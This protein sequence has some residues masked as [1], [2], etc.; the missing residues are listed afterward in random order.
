MHSEFIDGLELITAAPAKDTGKPPLLF[1]HGAFAGA[2]M[3]AERL[4]PWFAAQGYRASAVSLRGHGESFGRDQV[5]QHSIRDY[6]DDVFAASDAVARAAG[7]AP[8]LLG[9]SMGGFVIQKFLEHRP[10]P[11]AVLMCSVPPQGLLA[12]SFHLVFNNPSLFIDFNRLLG[13]TEIAPEA[14]RAA[15]FAHPLSDAQVAGFARRMSMESQRAIWDMSMFNLVALHAVHRTPLM[16][17]GTEHDQLIP[18]F[19]VQSTAQAYGVEDHLFR[20]F[21]HGFPLEPDAERIG[22]AVVH[23]LERLAGGPRQG[24]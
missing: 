15:L 9:H 20:G 1:V 19:L 3:W 8:I 13:G 24:Q 16:V 21:G 6:V 18:P 17:L 7:R 12:A 23:W 14:V 22:A 11:A 2:W 5:D 10:A 4:L